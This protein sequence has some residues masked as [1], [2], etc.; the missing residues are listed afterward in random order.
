MAERVRAVRRALLPSRAWILFQY[1]A[2]QRG[3]V[4]LIAAR[5]HHLLRAPLWAA[6]ALRYRREARRAG[7]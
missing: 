7:R 5:A 1:P 3:G 6:R 2:A 4:W